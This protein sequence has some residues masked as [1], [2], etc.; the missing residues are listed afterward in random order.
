MKLKFLKW[1]GNQLGLRVVDK[2]T[3]R[4][5]A[6]SLRSDLLLCEGDEHLSDKWRLRR[7]ETNEK[8]V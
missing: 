3:T 1:T 5:L 6:P 8:R 7:V 2:D 4:G